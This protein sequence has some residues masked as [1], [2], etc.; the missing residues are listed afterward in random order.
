MVVQCCVCKK[1]RLNSE[2]VK[3]SK[4]QLYNEKISHTYCPACAHKA[5]TEYHKKLRKTPFKPLSSHS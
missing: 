4:E 5:L 3:P 2:W 1:I